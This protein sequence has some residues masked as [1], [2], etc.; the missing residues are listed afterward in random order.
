MSRRRQKKHRQKAKVR[1]GG[2][3]SRLRKAAVV[4]V[5]VVVLC[6]CVAAGLL[7]SG[8]TGGPPAGPRAA[9]VD[10]LSLTQP[11]PEFAQSATSL[12]G[13][14]GYAVDYYPGEEVS[15]DFYRNLPTHDYEL[16]IL[17]VH[18]AQIHV[19]DDGVW[20]ATDDVSLFTS[21]PY[22]PVTS[23]DEEWKRGWRLRRVAYSE[24]GPYYFGIPPE[25]IELSMKGSFD[26]TT[27]ILMACSGLRSEASGQAF[28][29]KGAS[30]FVSWNA[31]VS[32]T[33]TDAATERILEHLLID[34]LTLREAVARTIAEVGPDPEFGAELHILTPG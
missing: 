33:H 15:V 27:V 1:R 6:A 24:D 2:G 12:L 34:K 32:A 25:F 9:I 23:E 21:E 22:R 11:N 3:G 13:Q 10:Q 19:P 20:T 8:L 17:R 26:G 7:L 29:D 18:A 28:L 5:S 16:L 30:A 31:S 4:V 14:A